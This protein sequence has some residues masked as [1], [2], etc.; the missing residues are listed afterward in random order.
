[1]P[2]FFPEQ[3]CIGNNPSNSRGVLRVYKFSTL[4]LYKKRIVIT[5][6]GGGKETVDVESLEVLRLLH[7]LQIR[8][9]ISMRMEK[10]KRMA[11]K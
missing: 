11:A 8:I 7:F 5:S 2:F 10:V 3:E 9:V 6:Y 4:P 1:M